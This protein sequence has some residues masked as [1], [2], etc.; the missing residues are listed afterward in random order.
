[1]KKWEIEKNKKLRE[2]KKAKGWKN[3][4]GMQKLVCLI[5]N[6]EDGRKE[7]VLEQ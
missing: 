2:G 4:G 6:K 1:M 7:T 3:G 5:N